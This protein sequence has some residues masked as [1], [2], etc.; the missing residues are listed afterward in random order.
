MDMASLINATVTAGTPRLRDLLSPFVASVSS[1][2]PHSNV[3]K[4]FGSG[5][6]VSVK[7]RPFLLS[8]AH[9]LGR[10]D[11]VLGVVLKNGAEMHTL[12]GAVPQSEDADLAVMEIPSEDWEQGDRQALH[13]VLLRRPHDVPDGEVCFFMGFPGAH[14]FPSVAERTVKTRAF[15]F[16]SR[17]RSL[18]H[19]DVVSDAPKQQFVRPPPGRRGPTGRPEVPLDHAVDRLDLPPLAVGGGVGLAVEPLPHHAPPDAGRRGG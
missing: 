5:L 17:L 1:R 7:G 8:N 16:V 10:T 14:S 12:S 9:V 6:F 19:H 11:L 15:C 13:R 4:H 3:A 2:E 18:Q